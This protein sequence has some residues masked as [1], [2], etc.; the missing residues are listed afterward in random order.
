MNTSVI[1]CVYIL[2]LSSS[3]NY[4]LIIIITIIIMTAIKIIS[5]YALMN[6]SANDEIAQLDRSVHYS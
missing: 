3:L 5:S 1:P 2:T 4:H 6:L